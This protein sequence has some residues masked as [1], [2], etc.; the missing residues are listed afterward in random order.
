MT[1][2]GSLVGP[3]SR[4]HLRGVNISA[5][6]V[7]LSSR[8]GHG[9]RTLVLVDVENI[10]G[11]TRFTPADATE[12][13]TAVLSASGVPADAHVILATSCDAALVTAGVA[14]P[15]ARLVWCPGPD[16]ADLA[17][18]DV[19]LNEDVASRFDRVVICSGDGLFAIVA[20]FLIA[21][22]V[23]VTVVAPPGSLSRKLAAA[24]ADVRVIGTPDATTLTRTTMPSQRSAAGSVKASGPVTSAAIP[25]P[26]FAKPRLDRS[27]L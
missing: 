11:G 3:R 7:G 15:G 6:P 17:L 25:R 19:V 23:A 13:R 16:G 18:A 20:R 9:D 26:H 10:I 8:S 22:D 14:W 1:R 2:G 24:A 12:A 21:Q 27:P 4:D 5:N